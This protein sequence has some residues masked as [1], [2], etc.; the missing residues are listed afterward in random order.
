MTTRSK[1]KESKS[2][3]K[4]F[5]LSEEFQTKYSDITR[6]YTVGKVL[7]LEHYTGALI[8]SPYYSDDSI[9]TI[10]TLGDRLIESKVI[11]VE[12]EREEF[13]GALAQLLARSILQEAEE[14]KA[15][16]SDEQQQ[17]NS[18][19][20]D[21]EQLRQQ[22]QNITPEQWGLSLQEKYQESKKCC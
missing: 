22:H 9:R 13:L 8:Q 16:A 5:E 3:V 12:F 17:K 4:E 19:Q 6:I 15:Q 7:I 21:I 1:S 10:K 14:E 20:E 2:K 18:I 11:S